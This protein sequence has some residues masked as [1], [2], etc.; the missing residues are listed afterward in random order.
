MLRGASRW[1]AAYLGS[2]AAFLVAAA[3]Y[4]HPGS[5][6]TFF[7][8][9]PAKQHERE[10]AA[11]RSAP[12]FD[13]QQSDGYDGQFYAQIAVDPLLKDPAIDRLVE[14]PYRAR[15]IFFSWTA[16]VLGLGRPAWILQAY[17]FQNIVCWLLLAWLLC[18][19]FPPSDARAFVLWAGCLF[20]PGVLASVRYALP[21]GPSALLVAAGIALLERGRPIASAI[22]T[23]VAALGRETA[24]L[25]AAA[26]SSLLRRNRRAWLLAALCVLIVGVPL[27]LWFDYLRSIYRA[28]A[29]TT[30]R[31]NF[32]A[33]LTALF[34]KVTA[35]RR[36][37]RRS[38]LSLANLLTLTSL[39]AFVVQAAVIAW[40]MFR[41]PRRSPWMFAAAPFV[42]L[43]FV[44]GQPVWEGSP[45]AYTRV[46]IPLTLGT[47]V[48]LAT[49]K[50]PWLMIA[51]ANAAAIPAFWTFVR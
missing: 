24:V 23:S 16:F 50:A 20:S 37:L 19:W 40:N 49:L 44:L 43:A 22:L 4:Y 8:E 51:A 29:F 46:L 6:F 12:H 14:T 26:Y 25:A 33:P 5:G 1:T 32:A 3:A 18:R 17:A 10:I 13:H 7:I 21:D 48:A 36:E 27:A 41:I 11:V 28:T 47:N 42:L 15:R 38:G 45:G 30:G 31:D 34:W 2:I 9:F 35:T 39:I